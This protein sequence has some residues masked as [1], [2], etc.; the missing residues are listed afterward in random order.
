MV[1]TLSTGASR[2]EALSWMKMYFAHDGL[3][4]AHV[5]STA[6]DVPAEIDELRTPTT[7][8]LDLGSYQTVLYGIPFQ[9]LTSHVE[10]PRKVLGSRFAGYRTEMSHF[11]RSIIGCRFANA[12]LPI[13]QDFGYPSAKG[14]PV[15]FGTVG[16]DFFENR[17]LVMDFVKGRVAVTDSEAEIPASLLSRA[18]FVP[19]TYDKGQIFVKLKVNGRDAVYLYDTGSDAFPLLTTR[20]DWQE[21]TGLAGDAT[22]VTVWLGSSWGKPKAFV[23]ARLKGDLCLGEDCLNHPL[24]FFAPSGPAGTPLFGDA[25]FEGRYIV[26][27]DIPR[28]RFGVIGAGN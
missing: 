19:L 8:Q 1:K 20:A 15:E 23:G 13:L 6:L 2:T 18:R 10:H 22:D 14:Q 24:A 3:Q 21:L 9:A 17:I 27:V 11:S 4:G 25:L 16:S 7:M 5:S 12:Q 26:I 28:R